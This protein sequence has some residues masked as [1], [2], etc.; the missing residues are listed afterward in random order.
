MK[1]VILA[2]GLG[3]R[4][5][6]ETVMRPK[7][8]VEIGSRPL[9]WHIMKCYASYGFKDFIVALGY[10]GEMIKE[11]FLNYNL[12]NS[13]LSIDLKSGN[14]TSKNGV[15]DDWKVRLIDTGFDTMTGGRISRLK[16]DIG[17]GTFM[18]TYGDG[19]ANVDIGKLLKFHRS[20][21]KAATVTAVRPIARFGGLSIGKNGNVSSFK[22]KTQTAE[23][24]I[25]G[26]F[27]VFEQE[28]FDYIDGD[29]AILERDPLEGL[30]RDGELVAYRHEGFWQCMD[31]VRDRQMLEELW[32][33]G[34]AP[35]RSWR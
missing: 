24:W 20:H 2:G 35:W 8:M 33:G 13:D 27:F 4:L 1:V 32:Q 3:T 30:A 11:Y 26:G 28:V 23:G 16:S 15:I 34:K 10:K 14:V 9:L 21:G 31:T 22:E 17:N 12:H 25:N 5:S 7:P 29:G 19:V 6:E 18:L